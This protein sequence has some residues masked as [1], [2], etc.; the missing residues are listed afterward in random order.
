MASKNVEIIYDG[1]RV[2]A[3]LLRGVN[4][5]TDIVQMTLGP[6]G[7]NVMIQKPW[8]WP[9]TTKDGVTVA[10]S[11][12]LKDHFENMGA[13]HLKHVAGKTCA[14]AGD[15][16]TTSTVLARAI[17]RDGAKLVAANH[18]PME[19]KRGIDWA[20][21]AIV[22]E[23]RTKSKPLE[24]FDEVKQVATVSA[25]GDEEIG[26]IIADAMKAVGKEGVITVDEGGNRTT[27]DLTEGMQFDQGFL[28]YV[29]IT[30][31]EKHQVVLREVSILVYNGVLRYQRE[32]MPILEKVAV[33]N[34]PIII[35]AE[36]I[37]D[38]ALELLAINRRRGQLQCVAVRAPGFGN[39]RLEN[40]VDI[41]T[42]T[43]AQVIDPTMT[44]PEEIEESDLGSAKTVIV[45]A[46]STTILEGAGDREAVD[47]RANK[48]RN[49]LKDLMFQPE[50]DRLNQRLARLIGGV[51]VISVGAATE[52]EMKEKKDRVDDALS[53]TRAGVAEGTVPGG[54]ITLYRLS[55]L[56]FD[57]P[58]NMH[59]DFYAGIDLL[60]RACKEP[61]KA[62]IKNTG[63]EPAEVASGL[64]RDFAS[65]Y[66]ARSEV[67]VNMYDAG[68]LDPAK[69]I[70]CSLENASSAAGLLL[71]TEGMIA[72]EAD[73]PALQTDK[74]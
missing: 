4:A 12:F 11:V 53:A 37:V 36:D 1:D 49:E 25:N 43:A 64:G 65:G 59:S 54:G 24:S 69:V 71:T 33:K 61:F 48:I 26:T 56:T 17:F 8:G 20:V 34:K 2:R 55:E 38:Q 3:K 21:K 18:N 41:A 72:D 42:M 15:G 62:I 46:G 19:L 60:C 58:T 51:G 31:P 66:N 32:L 57:P 68:I 30:D 13:M 74:N 35:I 27:L 10:R 29:F 73:D 5:L 9:H 63:K 39:K 45:E 47:R 28:H 23:L 40:L 70:R 16:T 52:T 14:D 22:E 6:S 67:Y 7:R 50:I 44:K